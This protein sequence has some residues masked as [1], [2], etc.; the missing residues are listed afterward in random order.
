MNIN[1]LFATIKR[2]LSKRTPECWLNYLR[3]QGMRIGTG[4]KL[5]SKPGAVLIDLTRPW[6]IEIG[7]NVQI[8]IGVKILTHGYDWS[9]I[10]GLY[11]EVLGSAGKVTIGDNCFIGMNAMI[12]KG[13]SIGNNTI[14]GAGSVV[15]GGVYPADCVLAGNP[16]RVICSLDEYR[17]KRQKAQLA[18]AIEL[19]CEY[20]KVFRQM[21]PEKELAE[22]FWL[23]E[24]RTNIDNKAFISKM[25]CVDNY[26][27]AME[28]FLRSKPLFHNYDAFIEYAL[29][30][31]DAVNGNQYKER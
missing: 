27:A 17:E 14:I 28:T 23:F 11:G 25:K 15:T 3:A 16:A 4:T 10:K 7:E 20:Y 31:R 9:V 5:F 21:P 26:E 2:I 6:L 1:K 13:T 24:E 8:T 30:N 18:E 29:K 12:L 22:F 19:V